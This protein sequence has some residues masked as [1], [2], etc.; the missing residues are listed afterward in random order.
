MNY[1]GEMRAALQQGKSANDA[2]DYF[3]GQTVEILLGRLRQVSRPHLLKQLKRELRD[4]NMTTGK[5][6]ESK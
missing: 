2:A 4:F 1:Y 5:W 3:C 6:G